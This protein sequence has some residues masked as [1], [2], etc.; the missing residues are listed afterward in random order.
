M[1]I[2]IENVSS[3]VTNVKE[4]SLKLQTLL[5]P[6]SCPTSEGQVT[7]RMV[8]QSL[9]DLQIYG[10]ESTSTLIAAWRWHWV[11]SSETDDICTVTKNG[12]SAHV[13]ASHS[14]AS[15]LKASMEL[16]M[17]TDGIGSVLWGR[18]HCMR[19][20]LTICK[21]M[22]ESILTGSGVQSGEALLTQKLKVATK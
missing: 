2:S 5:N 19:E 17:D 6:P 15:V 1:E 14:S 3:T 9:L 11:E 4:G 12:L 7:T 8:A 21:L 13:L 22:T 10:S 20:D 18:R 16:M